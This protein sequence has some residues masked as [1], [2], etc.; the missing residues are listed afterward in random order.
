MVMLFYLFCKK[1]KQIGG[2]IVQEQG[3]YD[4]AKYCGKRWAIHGSIAISLT[5]FITPNM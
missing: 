1:E 3:I 2:L 4:V 5:K